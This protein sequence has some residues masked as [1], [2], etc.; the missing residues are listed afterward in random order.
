[1]SKRRKLLSYALSDRKH[2]AYNRKRVGVLLSIVSVLVFLIFLTNFAV[3]IITGKKFG[4]DLKTLAAQ[5]HQTTIAVQAKRGTIFDRSGKPIADDST[6][7]S[8]YAI[9]SKEYVSANGDKLYVQSNQ[10]N[11][12]A[13]ILAEKLGME[14]DFVKD[15]LRLEGKYQVAFGS[16]GNNIGYGVKV[17]I[18]ALLKEAGITG[19]GFTAS[20]G[21]MYPNGKF[22]SQFIGY[23]QLEDNQYGTQSLVGKTFMEKDLNDI[24]AG[25][26]GLITYEKTASGVI[27]PGTE[28]IT[29]RVINGQDVYTTLSS[30]LQSY[31]E[32]NM[33]IFQSKTN[34]VLASATLVAAKTGEIL[35]T[36]QRPTFDLDT[37]EG[38][39][40]LSNWS[41]ALYQA[42]Y[43]P[44]STM[45][46]MTLASG[47]DA[48][49]FDPT[50]YYHNGGYTLIDT[51]INDWDINQGLSDGRHMTLAQGFAHS[52]N[53]A[54]L[55]LQQAMGD[56]TW[57]NYLYQFDFGPPT[58]FGMDHETFGIVNS[59]NQ[60]T[61]GMSAFGQGI[62]VTQIQMLKAF[63]AIAN[64]GEL[65]TPKFIAATYDPDTNTARKG[66]R[67]VVG[68]PVSS[69]AANQTLQY[70]VTVGTDP[71]NGTLYSPEVGAII[72][73]NGVPAAVKSGT[74]QI[75]K[76]DGTGY[77]EG[78]NATIN[79]VV[80]MYPSENPDFIMYV[81]L[82]QPEQWDY[83]FWRDVVNPVLEE[84]VR[85]KDT[86]D[87]TNP[88]KVLDDV[89]EETVYKLP[90]MVGEAPGP[91]AAE[92]RRY[93]IHPVVI[94]SNDEIEATSIKKGTEVA[95]NQRVL[96][97]TG[98]LKRLPDFYG[99]SEEDVQQFSEWTGIEIKFKGQGSKVLK[100][101]VEPDTS[102]EKLKKITITLGE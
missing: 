51:L 95:A 15:Q 24:L 28:T 21:R 6:T 82:Q 94:G 11:Q 46:V 71:Y 16:K 57:L 20:P 41:S 52:S 99:W 92:L 49:K 98:D 66:L 34:G 48:G 76:E 85:L 8:I 14:K 39:S 102:V 89:T 43:E 58:R 55:I 22:A 78:E 35:A 79:S 87:L 2:P 38:L 27:K 100:Q 53:I 12:V 67:E 64:Q 69:E 73:V 7:Y 10:Y 30:E 77:M 101:S 18:E 17:E 88:T 40:D 70:M 84:A 33:D 56:E 97:W 37:K 4:Q 42:Q 93:L 13:D 75:A 61:I 9:L 36:T 86:L 19:I 54:M 90:K 50:Y 5:R 32:T 63:T 26:D 44:G 60:V 59:D 1:M 83:L 96:L 68:K 80:A 74:S 29:Q 31:L 62:S 47:I 3:I 91:M 45:K 65:L 81:M 25:T 72:Q 23:T